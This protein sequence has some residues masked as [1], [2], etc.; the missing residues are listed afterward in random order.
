M[1]DRRENEALV[2][3]ALDAVNDRDVTAL[4]ACFHPDVLWR[5]TGRNNPLGGPFD[6]LGAVL[7]FFASLFEASADTLTLEVH[8]IMASTTHAA[9]MVRITGTR[10]ERELDDQTVFI[11]HFRD[12][13]VREVWSYSEDQASADE[14]WA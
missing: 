6:G 11:V 10:G 7:T 3:R 5:E 14:F 8:D 2:R 1:G 12:G 13:L 9:A 4:Q